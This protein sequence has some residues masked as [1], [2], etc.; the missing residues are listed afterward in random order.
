MLQTQLFHTIFYVVEVGLNGGHTIY[1]DSQFRM[2]PF[3]NCETC[4]KSSLK[5]IWLT[6]KAKL[7]YYSL[8][9]KA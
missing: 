2:E 3:S 6:Y 9:A 1:I 7:R 8:D 5:L 4:E